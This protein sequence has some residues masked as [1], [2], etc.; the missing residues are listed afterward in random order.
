MKCNHKCKFCSCPWDAPNSSY[1]KKDELSIDDWKNAIDVLYSLG[2]ES[3]SISGGEALLK[4]GFE[5]ILKYIRVEANKRNI[6]LPIILISN[7]KKMT[8]DYLQLFKELNVHLS[9]S[10]PGYDTFEYHTGV[11]NADGVLHWFR[12]AKSWS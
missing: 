2:V 8:L 7:A 10:L 3:F 9:M 5:E 1:L 11:D 6:Q 12:M 4:E